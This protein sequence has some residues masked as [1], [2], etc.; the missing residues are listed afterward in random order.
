M[1]ALKRGDRVRVVVLS[2]RVFGFFVSLR[3]FDVPGLVEITSY[4][5]S[6]VVPTYDAVAVL[7]P[8][9]PEIGAEVDA[10]VLGFRERERQIALRYLD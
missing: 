7:H 8:P 4:R 2:H 3:E 9:Y 6:G 5:P 10:E 1:S